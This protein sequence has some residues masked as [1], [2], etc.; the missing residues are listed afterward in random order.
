MDQLAEEIATMARVAIERLSLAGE[1]VEVLLGGGLVQAANGP[2]VD[3]VSQRVTDVA[4][5][6]IV[7]STSSP[8]IVG[9]AL[10]GLD[11]LG[12]DGP[13]QQ[14]LRRELGDRFA[15]IGKEAGS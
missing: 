11:E 4:P 10:L 13:A 7:S 1:R 5:A 12:A 9:A 14:R 15:R 3:A 8:P 2:L 6:A